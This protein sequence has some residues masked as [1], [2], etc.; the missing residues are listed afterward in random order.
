MKINNI[1]SYTDLELALM[2]LLDY[3]GSG[4]VRKKK[5]GSRY[6]DVQVLVNFILAYSEIP[7]GT[8]NLTIEELHRALLD[9]KP[10]DDDYNEYCE[11]L[12][13]RVK[14]GTYE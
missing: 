5:L 4:Q 13:Y 14:E 12:I 2:V 1:N 3:L 9:M 6:H 7:E 11:Q 8:G 10:S